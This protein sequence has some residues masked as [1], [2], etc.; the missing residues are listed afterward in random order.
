MANL[1][2]VGY[3]HFDFGFYLFL[4]PLLVFNNKGSGTAVLGYL[5]SLS[6][7]LLL[8]PS[9]SAERG[10]CVLHRRPE[11]HLSSLRQRPRFSFYFCWL[12]HIRTCCIEL[13]I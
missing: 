12:L 6:Q 8:A 1:D 13:R 10:N 7:L 2:I 5:S 3:F 9:S 4:S 11:Y